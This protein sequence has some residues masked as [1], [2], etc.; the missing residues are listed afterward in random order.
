MPSLRTRIAVNGIGAV[1]GFGC[2]VNDLEKS[3]S[4][5]VCQPGKVEI[6]SG[7]GVIEL[8]VFNAETQRLESYVPKRALRRV[9]HFSR[10][11]VL[12]GYLALEDAG[13]AETSSGNMG[14]VVASGYGAAQTTFGFLDTIIEAGDGCAS[15]T[16]FSNS[17]HNAAAAQLSIF[18]RA[19]G[20]NITISQFEMSVPSAL[21][22]ACQLLAEKM[23]DFVLFGGVDEYCSVLG[24]CRHRLFPNE[25][26][27]GMAPLHLNQQSAIV[28]EGSAFFLLSRPEDSISP[29][30]FITNIIFGNLRCEDVSLPPEAFLILGADG[31]KCCGR[32]YAEQIPC[33][34]RVAVYANLYGSLP[35]GPAFDMAIAAL[36]LKSGEIFGVPRQA[37]ENPKWQVIHH[38]EKLNREPIYC[39]KFNEN[40]DFGFIALERE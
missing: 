16:F 2:G 9:D 13:Y 38:G 23:V 30:C 15:P 39:V 18:S 12:G 20:P 40:G 21:V 14:I 36:S 34:S 19:T 24:Y 11:A 4:D 6:I 26:P 28:G 35:I 8:P 31:H 25:K 5:R 1:G 22:T 33:G 29:Y 32:H 27:E 37:G 3:L 10:I 17:V 7:E